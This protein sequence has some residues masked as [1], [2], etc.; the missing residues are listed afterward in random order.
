MFPKRDEAG[1]TRLRWDENGLPHSVMFD[2]KYFC[3]QSGY[4]EGLHV[5]CGGNRLK[6]RFEGLSSSEPFVIGETGFGTG[7][8]F[9]CAWELFE[10]HAPAGAKLHYVSL[11]Q[12]PLNAG[13]LKR[14]L[15]LWPRLSRYAEQLTAQYPSVDAFVPPVEFAGGRVKLMLI[16]D[17]VV[18]AL[19]EMKRR[20]YRMDAWFLDGF[21]PAKNKEMWSDDVFSGIAALSR[22]G[23]TVATFTSAGDVRR[24]LMKHGFRMEK[25]PGFGRKRHM[26]RGEFKSD[27]G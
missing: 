7:L 9:L 17:H 3:Q 12:F 20:G 10:R 13:D 5:F 11:D 4:D 26:L 23:T 22:P 25:A 2:D 27:K 18:S 8:N 19:A 16:Y 1:Y 15:N 21:S 14:A 24:G 6:E